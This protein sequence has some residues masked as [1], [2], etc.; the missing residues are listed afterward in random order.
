MA[1]KVRERTGRDGEEWFAL[2]DEWGAA[3]RSHG[4]IVGRLSTYGIGNWWAQ[5]LTVEYERARG[6]RAPNQARGGGFSA[7]AGKTVAVPV[8]RLYEA[9]TEDAVRAGARVRTATPPK[10]WRADWTGGTRLAAG[11]VSKGD[12]RSQVALAHEKL[13]GAAAVEEAKAYWRERLAALKDRL[14]R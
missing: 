1:G 12:G 6:L 7:T 3:K 9:F 13:A 5:H 8:E 4:E 10:T 11:F 2:L 14:E